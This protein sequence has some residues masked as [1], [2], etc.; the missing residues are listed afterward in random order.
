M[1]SAIESDA[2]KLPAGLLALGVHALFFAL[3]YFGFAWQAQKPVAM[4][5]ELWQ[6]LPETAPAPPVESKVQEV[7]PPPPK[8]IEE[9]K[10]DIVVPDKKK[11]P[12]K[13]PEVKPVEKK[14]EAKPE[15]K[16]PTEVKKAV[17]P[18]PSKPSAAEQQAARDK[19]VQEAAVGQVVDEY[20]AKIAT[21]IRRNTVMPPG[22]PDEARA[23]FLV[24]LLPGGRVLNARLSKSSGNAAYDAAV[25]RAI[26]K[27]DPL[28]LPPDSSLFNRFRELKL[29]FKPVE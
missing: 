24:T 7:A 28:P 29:G 9:V 11:P 19:A 20:I 15:P 16:K 1:N 4:S 13:K 27:S 23:E 21:K 10:P 26:L 25:E 6:S 22:V 14:P 17:V 8:V 3:L 5:V 12:E 18:A 2:Y